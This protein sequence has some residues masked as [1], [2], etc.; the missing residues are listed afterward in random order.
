MKKFIKKKLIS[1][2]NFIEIN[3]RVK[4]STKTP[5]DIHLEEMSSDCYKLF[6]ENMKKSSIFLKDNEIRK[7]SI[8][9]ALNNN[10][11]NDLFLEFGVF[12]GYSINLFANILSKHRLEIYGF[13]SF[14]GLEENRITD[15]INPVGTFS[16]NKKKP[17]V[18][19][20]VKLIVGKVQETLKNFLNNQNEKKIIFAHMDLD[21]YTPT[22][23]VLS[24]IKPF[25]KKGSIVLFDEFYGFPN[26]EKYEY[27]AFKEVF[28]ENEYK[29]I[30]FGTRQ[31]AVE[32]L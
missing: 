8:L 10:G 29:Y 11:N 32:I 19:K 15:E 4:T 30:A 14:E 18:P 5:A 25:L 22:R 17:P 16:L 13:D 27:R 9:N 3:L 26:W 21:T 24:E 12:K 28:K 23:Y 20:N 2:L 6:K 7:H 31:V 1:I